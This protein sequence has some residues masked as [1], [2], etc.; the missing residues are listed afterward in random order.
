MAASRRT[1]P[2]SAR[3]KT[4]ST[5]PV[6]RVQALRSILYSANISPLSGSKMCYVKK[7]MDAILFIL[8]LVS[9]IM[10]VSGCT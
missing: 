9:L 8:M 2:P 6:G 5:E 3:K 4:A 1:D 10:A 7:S